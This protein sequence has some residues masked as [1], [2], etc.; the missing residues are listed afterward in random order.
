MPRWSIEHL[1]SV[2][3]TQ[4]IVAERLRGG[5]EEGVVVVADTQ[6]AGRG[7]QGRRWQSDAGGLYV[8]VG[9][10]PYTPSATAGAWSLLAGLAVV[11]AVQQRHLGRIEPWLKWP[12]DVYV[13]G[14]KLAGVLCEGGVAT[15]RVETLV[16]GIGINVKPPS[17]GWDPDMAVAPVALDEL[18]PTAVDRPLLGPL[19]D[20][21]DAWILCYRTEG[22][23]AIVGPA[24]R[25]M[26]PFFGQRVRTDGRIPG[27]SGF[28]T[29]AD[30][31]HDGA[32]LVALSDGTRVRTVA[33][34][35]QILRE[36]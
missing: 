29:A 17:G 1:G 12:N 20:A 22:I 33:G 24:R 26:A 36:E 11:D 2:R 34:D 32:L 28:A 16:L 4:E 18:D 23:G 27:A 7:R 5:A 21:L 15:E 19:L 6:A 9:L 8:S 10:R 35:V 13:D 25:A 3:S 30:L 14:R 31:D